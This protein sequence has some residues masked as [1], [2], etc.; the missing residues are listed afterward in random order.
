[1]T[2][3]AAFAALSMNAQEGMYIG[4]TGNFR[5]H[6]SDDQSFTL[7][8]EFG[9][10]LDDN[11]GVGIVLTYGSRK[12]V[13][14]TLGVNPYLR[15]NALSI[16][17][18][19]VFVDGGL[20]FNTVKPKNGDADNNFGLN[21]VPGIAYNIT[22]KFSIVAHANPLF[23]WNVEAPANSKCTNTIRLLDRFSVNTF[24][25]GFYYNF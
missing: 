17:K 22:D 23:Q 4:G 7:A 25:F 19:N 21:I 5:F 3:V 20:Y 1:M 2:I 10:N 13:N 6:G 8:P 14:T 12:D 9:M 18:V 16:G 24:N 11:L 15:Y